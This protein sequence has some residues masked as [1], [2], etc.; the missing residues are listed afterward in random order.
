M[1][2]KKIGGAV[3]LIVGLLFLYFGLQGSGT[4]VDQ[5]YE[6][7]TGRYTETTMW[8]LVGGTASAV[9]G[10]VLIVRN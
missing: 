9:V 3:L 1:D 10:L 4:P 5:V 2:V 6:I 8:F 7:F